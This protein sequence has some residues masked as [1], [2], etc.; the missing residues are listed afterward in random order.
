MSQ[1]CNSPVS[2]RLDSEALPQSINRPHLL[3]H[4]ITHHARFYSSD[5]LVLC[6]MGYIGCT[7]EQIIDSVPGVCSDRGA[8][9][10]S[11]NGFT[12]DISV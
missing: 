7:M 9:V 8:A 2:N 10:R 12:R 11:S 1:V 3:T 4:V 6:V 5:R